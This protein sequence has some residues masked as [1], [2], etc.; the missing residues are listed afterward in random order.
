MDRYVDEC[1]DKYIGWISASKHLRPMKCS[2]FTNSYVMNKDD[3]F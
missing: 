3:L 1:V 2:L